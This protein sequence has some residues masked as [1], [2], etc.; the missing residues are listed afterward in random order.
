M[1]LLEEKVVLVTG[2]TEPETERVELRVVIWVM[3]MVLVELEGPTGEPSVDE[4][5]SVPLLEILLKLTVTVVAL[6]AVTMP[7]EP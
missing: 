1:G 6:L 5:E 7:V 4:V 3:T 2:T